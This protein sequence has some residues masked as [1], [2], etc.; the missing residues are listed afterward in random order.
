[1]FLAIVLF[2]F[3]FFLLLNARSRISRLEHRIT[4]LEQST[5]N[6]LYR[7]AGAKKKE[8]PEA[9]PEPSAI[10]MPVPLETPEAEPAR[11]AARVIYASKRPDAV[12]SVEIPKPVEMQDEDSQ[13][14]VSIKQAV[15]EIITPA[16]EKAGSI[17]AEKDID[18]SA[19]KSAKGNDN[20]RNTPPPPKRASF[21]FEEFFGRRLPIWAGGITLAIAGVLIVKYAYD[22]GMLSRW[23]QVI[24]GLLF[25]TGLIAGAEIAFR[26]EASV[27][28]PRV[29]QALSGAGLATLYATVL[30]A[31]NA[32]ALISP[33]TAFIAMAAVTAGALG[34]SIRFGAP[35]ALLGLAGGLATPALVGSLQ[36]DVP[37]LSLYLTLTIGGLTAVSRTQRWAWLGV[38]ALIGGAGWGAYLIATSALDFASSLSIG[39]LVI[40]LAIGLPFV[41]FSGP[42][43]S[44]MRSASAIIGAAQIA[45]LVAVGGYSPLNW[46]LFGLIAVA[47]QWLS[48]REKGF[49]IVPSISLGI[50]AMLLVVWPDPMQPLFAAVA[51]SM[52]IIHGVPLMIRLW[53]VPARFQIA[54]E[55]AG[56][57]LAILI[58]PMVQFYALDGS[59]DSIFGLVAVFGAM[60][61][62][63]CVTLGWRREERHDD[64]R[65]AMLTTTSAFLGVCAYWFVTA[66]WSWPIGLAIAAA[67][68]LLFGHRAKDARLEK[69]AAIFALATLPFIV[70]TGG[71]NMPEIFSLF[72]LSDAP[73]DLYAVGRWMVA[74]ALFILFAMRAELK[75]LRFAA[76][77]IAALLGYGMLA[78]IVP[79]W[80]VPIA[81]VASVAT[82]LLLGHRCDD[83][84][85][86]SVTGLI[87]T[88]A[89]PL[90]VISASSAWN[91]WSRLFGNSNAA[92]ST[93]SVIRWA[94]VAALYALFAARAKAKGLRLVGYLA[95]SIIGYG[96]LAQ[97]VPGWSVP[98]ALSASVAALLLF[99][100]R[101]DDKRIEIFAGLFSV[102]TIL[103]LI[104]TGADPFN[105]LLRL[106]GLGDATFVFQPVLRWTGVAALFLLFAIRAKNS[107]LRIS[108]QA[109]ATA[110][111]YGI[112]AQMLPPML[113]PLVPATGVLALAYASKKLA[114]PSLASGLAV[115]AALALA[116]TVETA[117][118]WILGALLSLASIP[119]MVDAGFPNAAAFLNHL[120]I[121]GMLMGISIWLLRGNLPRKAMQLSVAIVCLL[122]FMG[123]HGLYRIGFAHMLP[124]DFAH[125]GV[126]QRLIWAVLLISAGWAVWRRYAQKAIGKPL[127]LT[128]IGAGTLHGLYYGLLLHNPLWNEQAVGGLPVVNLL[129]PIF[130]LVPVGIW[131]LSKIAPDIFT[132][133]ARILQVCAMILVTLFSYASLRQIFHGTFLISPGTGDV[134][135]ILRSIIAIALAIG[136]LLWGIRHKQRDWRIA[137]L[138]LMIAAVGKVFLLDASGLQGLM[139]IG[140]FVALGFSLIGLGWLYSRQLRST[141]PAEANAMSQ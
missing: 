140:S 98:I 54:L 8:A 6:N 19:Y 79:G 20:N 33:L 67:I 29:R 9:K 10:Q 122:G 129:I 138:I 97:I 78:Q 52:A 109:T 37:L 74:T 121:P 24:G 69:V 32:Y 76:A 3:L 100:E 56:L 30:V 107:A 117:S 51:I 104:N 70:A 65:F 90:L 50:S 102:G 131:L 64:T 45:T 118:I 96:A 13:P 59:R 133:F 49:E 101:S 31:H 137:S 116:W 105:E 2:G 114:W 38:S 11:L 63:T 58:I 110:L 47:G 27:R 94:V 95:A 132:R 41:A 108:M 115:A 87:A 66:G 18:I 139:R 39:G 4:L 57:S 123:I 28:D 17:P 22:A 61:A 81:L 124:G 53:K 75:N 99:G 113:L 89:V 120:L 135:D 43:A 82:L 34:L 141:D 55:L 21:N 134:E 16:K 84:R 88:A 91:E 111:A 103:L 26:K 48:W 128:L 7:K 35:S 15:N 14:A 72:G 127:A 23:V 130:G 83:G 77:I 106:I 85:I 80:A 5:A 12:L 44:L 46:G 73:V 25:G 60:L 1:M 112:L 68:L 93:E 40:L 126:V 136:F 119:L 125:S 42:R 36:P 92:F 71:R 62:A 86:E